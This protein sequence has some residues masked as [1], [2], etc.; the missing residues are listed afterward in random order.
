MNEWQIPILFGLLAGIPLT[1]IWI[2]Y[3]PTWKKI[4]NKITVQKECD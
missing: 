1:A 2:S 3:S 4:W